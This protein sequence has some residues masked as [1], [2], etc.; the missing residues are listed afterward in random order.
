[1]VALKLMDAGAQS[2]KETWL[3]LVLIDAGLPAPRTQVRVSDGRAEAFIDM[4]YEEPMI[5]LDYEG[6]QHS[7]DRMRY[8]HDIGRYELIERQGWLDIRVV[9]EHSRLFVLH[10]A[11]QA[12]RQRGQTLRLLPG[13]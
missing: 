9:A 4:G 8:V 7:T 1:M 2:P 12:F 3:R 10:R 6:A 11:E 5:G 13:R